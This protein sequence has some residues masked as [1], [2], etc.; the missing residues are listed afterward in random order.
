VTE[1]EAKADLAQ[2][3]TEMAGLRS[4]AVP[5]H[6]ADPPVVHE[7]LRDDLRAR[8]DR[9]EVLLAA[10]AKHRRRAKAVALA[11]V[12]AADDAYDEHLEKLSGRAVT[13]EFESI[14]DREVLARVKSSPLRKEARAAERFADQV[15][16]AETAMRG[17][18]F[19]LRDIRAELLATLQHYVPWQ[20][21][22][23]H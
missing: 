15:N 11:A 1:D 14:K 19:G 9:A 17:M 10:V 8:L 16:E 13:R 23:E 18:F 20:S 7:A 2:L 22:L 3:L 6:D 5:P 21:S 4:F 12:A